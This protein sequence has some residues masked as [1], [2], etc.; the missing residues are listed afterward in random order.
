MSV[1]TLDGWSALSTR[2]GNPAALWP[3]GFVNVD[4]FKGFVHIGYRERY[5]TVIQNSWCSSACFSV[6][7]L[8]VSINSI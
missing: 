5:H 4:L 3:S 8:E 6:A 1:K 2:P 7:C